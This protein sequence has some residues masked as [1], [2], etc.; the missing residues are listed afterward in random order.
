MTID[1]TRRKLL[2]GSATAGIIAVA[3][4]T[5]GDDD[6]DDSETD[7]DDDPDES[8][9]EEPMDDD[10]GEDEE[11]ET[12]DVGHYE[13]WASI[14]DWTTSTS[15]SPVRATTSSTTS[16]KST[17]TDSRAFRTRASRHT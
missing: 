15:T 4:C 13:V 9:D 3:G 7:T 1:P 11:T 14:R 5:S 2:A 16:K 12:E 17:S 6:P 8:D 10:E